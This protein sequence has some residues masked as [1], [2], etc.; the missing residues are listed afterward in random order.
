MMEKESPKPPEPTR[1]RHKLSKKRRIDDLAG[2]Y[3]GVISEHPD[4]AY[5]T[6]E[7]KKEFLKAAV[8]DAKKIIAQE[9]ALRKLPKKKVS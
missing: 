3:F 5:A 9:D 1:G 2:H 8:E 6:P 4:S 7:Q